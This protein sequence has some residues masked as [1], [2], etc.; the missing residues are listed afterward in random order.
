MLQSHHLCA[1]SCI[2]SILPCLSWISKPRTKP[3]TSLNVVM[4]LLILSRYDSLSELH[5]E[6]V[7]LFP[8]VYLQ[9]GWDSVLQIL[10]CR[11]APSPFIPQPVV[12]L[13]IALTQVKHF[14]LGLAGAYEAPLSPLLKPV[15][16]LWKSPPSYSVLAVP[17]HVMSELALCLTVRASKILTVCVPIRTLRS[18]TALPLGTERFTVALWTRPSRNFFIQ[19]SLCQT[20][21]FAIWQQEFSWFHLLSWHLWTLSN[22]SED[23]NEVTITKFRKIYF[24]P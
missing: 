1:L 22:H 21:T 6:T 18:L 15:R 10:F 12:T 13:G 19:R 24:L 23:V 17:L 14:V 16:F 20:H 5:T 4:V 11:A 3:I 7:Y 2:F 8:I 9:T